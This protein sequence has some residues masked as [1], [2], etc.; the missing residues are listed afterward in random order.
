LLAGLVVAVGA[1]AAVF[2]LGRTKHDLV[3]SKESPPAA[4]V[5]S[6]LA[7]DSP[8]EHMD[9]DG[10]FLWQLTIQGLQLRR[11]SD[12]AIN[13]ARRVCARYAGGESQ[14]QIIQDILQGSPGMSLDTASSFADTAIDVYCPNGYLDNP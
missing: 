7:A 14:Q 11:S 10:K 1:I 4:H 9:K 6:A 3:R 8:G 13:D 5:A 12:A 2:V